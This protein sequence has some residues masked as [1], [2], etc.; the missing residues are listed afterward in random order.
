MEPYL[1]ERAR[2]FLYETWKDERPML[3]GRG[4]YMP[5]LAATLRKYGVVESVEEIYADVWHRIALVEESISPVHRLRS[6]GTGCTWRP[7]RSGTAA[8]T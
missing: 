8:G 7:T 4:D 3:A 2:D 5:V 6:S 1:G